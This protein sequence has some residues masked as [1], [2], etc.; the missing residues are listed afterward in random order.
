MKYDNVILAMNIPLYELE[1]HSIKAGLELW[2]TLK[3]V[4]KVTETSRC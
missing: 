4:T 3:M 1:V 2:T